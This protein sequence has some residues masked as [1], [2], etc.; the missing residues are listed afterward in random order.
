MIIVRKPLTQ[1]LKLSGCGLAMY[2]SIIKQGMSFH[3]LSKFRPY[4]PGSCEYWPKIDTKFQ[5]HYV[6][7]DARLVSVSFGKFHVDSVS[8]G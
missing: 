3:H 1:E 2:I 4:H 6:L 7:D 8:F 5:F